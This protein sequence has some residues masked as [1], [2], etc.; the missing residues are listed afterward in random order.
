M[1]PENMTDQEMSE[2]IRK[3]WPLMPNAEVEKVR[4]TRAFLHRVAD[5]LLELSK[6]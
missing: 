5:R 4:E 2:A 3:W 6:P 1:F